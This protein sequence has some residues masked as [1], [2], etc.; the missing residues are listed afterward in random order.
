MRLHHKFPYKTPEK[1]D[2]LVHV[3]VNISVRGITVGT[4]GSVCPTLVTQAAPQVN[5]WR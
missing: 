2:L 3:S 5:A 1:T 4:Q